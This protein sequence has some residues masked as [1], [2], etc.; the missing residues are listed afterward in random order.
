MNKQLELDFNKKEE[1]HIFNYINYQCD[2]RTYIVYHDETIYI[3]FNNAG[4]EQRI[5][6]PE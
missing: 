3:Y 4:I 5:K 2:E 1:P 6:V